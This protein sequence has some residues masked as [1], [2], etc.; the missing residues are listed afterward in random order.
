MFRTVEEL[1]GT[2]EDLDPAFLPYTYDD[3]RIGKVIKHPLV[4]S[5][6]HNELMNAMVNE[7]LKAKTQAAEEALAKRDYSSFIFLHERPYRFEAFVRAMDKMKD[8]EYWELL[9][10]A[11]VD[12]ENLWQNLPRWKKLLQSTRKGREFFMQEEERNFLNSLPETV[13]I[14]RGYI[15]SKN[16]GGL[17]YTLN[18]EKAHWFANR[19]GGKG[20]VHVR[21]IKKSKIFA[22]LSR[23]DEDEIIAL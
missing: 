23:R 5:I 14:F 11:W 2:R 12:S 13:K 16:K 4:F 15:P 22:Y 10:D 18:E 7:R 9:G 17:S 1:F 6:M 8:K 20:E 19:F 3:P 21:T